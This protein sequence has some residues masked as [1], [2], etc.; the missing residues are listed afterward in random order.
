MAESGR[1]S[2]LWHSW[3]QARLVVAGYVQDAPNFRWSEWLARH[4]GWPFGSCWSASH[5]SPSRWARMREQR[6]KLKSRSDE[7][8]GPEQAKR[9]SGVAAVSDFSFSL[10]VW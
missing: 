1:N 3:Y 7:D 9:R 5:R 4:V 10:P 6:A 2:L 8:N